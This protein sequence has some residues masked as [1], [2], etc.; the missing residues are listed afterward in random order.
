MEDWLKRNKIAA[1]II[2]V[3]IVL[4]VLQSIGGNGGQRYSGLGEGRVIW[5]V[6][7]QTG[8]A[9]VCQANNKSCSAWMR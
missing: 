2:A 6:D 8:Q 4:L 9:K 5:V 1:G 3:L 7:G